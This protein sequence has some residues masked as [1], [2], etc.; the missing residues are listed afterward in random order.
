MERL[1]L[2]AVFE[3]LDVKPPSNREDAGKCTVRRES[4]LGERYIDLLIL[5]DSVPDYAIAVEVKT[6]DEQFSKNQHYLEWLNARFKNPSCVLIAIPEDIKKKIFMVS[7][8]F[9]G[10]S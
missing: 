8:C 6:N 9:L 5:F 10:A 1:E 4:Q 3:V 7:R 2:S